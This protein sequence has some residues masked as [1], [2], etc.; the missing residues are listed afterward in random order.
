MKITHLR[1]HAA[2]P[3]LEKLASDMWQLIQQTFPEME[4]TLYPRDEDGF[5]QEVQ[6]LVKKIH[7]MMDYATNS[8]EQYRLD[9]TDWEA[10]EYRDLNV[11]GKE[12]K[13]E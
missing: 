8:P 1:K 11:E 6:S 3:N 12:G 10:E 5:K 9:N 2:N 13:E 4:Y 7:V